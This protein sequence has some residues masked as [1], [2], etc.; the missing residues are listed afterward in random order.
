M[1][2]REIRGVVIFFLVMMASAFLLW[3]LVIPINPGVGNVVEGVTST[4]VE[5]AQTWF[6]WTL[7]LILSVNLFWGPIMLVLTVKISD[8]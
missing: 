3:S 1:T 6:D 2:R 8:F 7:P 4:Y 5:R